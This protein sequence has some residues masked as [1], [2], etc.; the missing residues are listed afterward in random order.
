VR[1]EESEYHN[2]EAVL[3]VP[4][5]LWPALSEIVCLEPAGSSQTLIEAFVACEIVRLFQERD[6]RAWL[7]EEHSGY[8]PIQTRMAFRIAKGLLTAAANETLGPFA[9]LE[10]ADQLSALGEPGQRLLADSFLHK[11]VAELVDKHQLALAL[12]L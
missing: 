7:A 11:E 10:G 4:I 12:G 8:G 1:G 3:A 9:L 6:H 2:R 5:D